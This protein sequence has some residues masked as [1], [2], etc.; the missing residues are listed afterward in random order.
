MAHPEGMK[1][2]IIGVIEHRSIILRLLFLSQAH[3]IF[4]PTMIVLVRESG[5]LDRV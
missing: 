4:P 5:S 1:T 3:T 2:A